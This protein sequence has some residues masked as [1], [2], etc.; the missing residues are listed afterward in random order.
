MAIGNFDIP[1]AV[2]LG[3]SVAY[4]YHV[5][6][7]EAGNSDQFPNASLPDGYARVGEV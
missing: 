1:R 6:D 5:Y 3:N 2:A 7:I 4:A